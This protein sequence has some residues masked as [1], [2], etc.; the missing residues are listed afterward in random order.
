MVEILTVTIQGLVF[1]GEVVLQKKWIHKKSDPE[2]SKKSW[3]VL[4]SVLAPFGSR[5]RAETQG[6]Q[7]LWELSRS[8]E[9]TRF[10]TN[11]EHFPEQK[12][13]KKSDP[14]F[15]QNKVFFCSDHF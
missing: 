8:P 14:P 7:R 10:G 12:N 5:F 3:P 4:G 1:C 9:G 6:K 13:A 11:F 15:E 2:V